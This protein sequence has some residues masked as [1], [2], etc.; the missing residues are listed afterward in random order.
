MASFFYTLNDFLIDRESIFD[1]SGD[2][3]SHAVHFLWL[4]VDPAGSC[5]RLL[6]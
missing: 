1:L 3:L 4:K 2:C 6:C 5:D